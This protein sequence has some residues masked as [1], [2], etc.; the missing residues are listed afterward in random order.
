MRVRALTAA[1]AFG[2]F[3]ASLSAQQPRV[4]RFR[5]ERPIDT[6]GIGPRRLA[7]DVSLLGGA[8]SSLADLRLFDQQGFPVAYILL[9]FPVRQTTWSDGKVLPIAATDETSGFEAD[10]GNAQQMDGVQVS[11]LQAP[12]LKRLMLEGSGDR[13]HWTLLAREATLFDL[14]DEGL[15]QI[16]LG[17]PSGT[18]RYLRVTWD[19]RNS[20]R[21]ALPSTVQARYHPGFVSPPPLTMRLGVER[22]MSEPGRSRYRVKLPRAHLP[23]TALDVIVPGDVHVYRQAFVRESRLSGLSMQPA[24]LGVARLTQVAR[25]GVVAASMRIPI[26]PPSEPEVDLVI[27]DGNNPPLD[28]NAVSLV[29]D[30]LPWIYFEAPADGLIARYGNASAARPSYDLEAVRNTVHV[31]SVAD[32]SWGVPRATA[33]AEPVAAPAPLPDTGPELDAN[34]FAV[35]RTIPSGPAG[36]VSLALDADVLGRSRGLDGQFADVRILDGSNRQLPYVLEKRDEPMTFPLSPERR[37]SPDSAPRGNGGGGRSY[38]LIRLPYANVPSAQL[39]IETSARVFQRGVEIFEVQPADRNHRAPWRLVRQVTTWS[40]TDNDERTSALVLPLSRPSGT[41]LWLSIDE[42]DNSPL[43]VTSASLLLPS[44]RL[45]FYRPAAASL[46]LVYGRDDLGAP[47][48]DFALLAP[49]VLGVEAQELGSLPPVVRGP[50]MPQEFIS[51]R[52]F[53]IFLSTAVLVLLALIVRL[54]RKGDAEARL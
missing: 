40:H 48:Y 10:F 15:R 42:G 23:V 43:P 39:A 7:P 16:E 34:L 28:V 32:A 9:Q 41:E 49:Q 3:V 18:Y 14:P 53:W 13:E 31:E 21:V 36:L 35:Q 2:S 54:A 1:A 30:N 44:Y 52:T 4:D 17:F 33:P 24:D 45:R 38:Y 20:G 8:Q 6:R 27:E 25:Q 5:F 50:A 26:Q 29:F 51:P 37:D 11:G 12:F 19:D 47:R 46:R 22:R